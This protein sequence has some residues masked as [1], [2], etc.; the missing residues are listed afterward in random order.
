MKMYKDMKIKHSASSPPYKVWENCF[1]KK[2]LHGGTNFFGQIYVEKFYMGTN[3]QVMQGVT[4]MIE[5]FQTSGQVCFLLIDPAWPELLIYYLK[6]N[7]TN[8]GLN[9]KNT[10]CKLCHWGWTFH[11]K[12][13]LFSKIFSCNLFFGVLIIGLF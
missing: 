6:V 1:C 7:T 12:P 3:D 5:R 8:R 2:A 11:L 4:L 10:F 9:L 13:V